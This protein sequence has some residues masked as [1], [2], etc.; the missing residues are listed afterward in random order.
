MEPSTSSSSLYVPSLAWHVLPG[1]SS[2]TVSGFSH[3]LYVE[4]YSRRSGY[5]YGNCLTGVQHSCSGKFF[6]LSAI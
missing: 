4:Y 3:N 1:D 2:G 5:C 6:I